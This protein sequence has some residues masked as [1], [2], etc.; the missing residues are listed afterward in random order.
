[1]KRIE[2]AT[3]YHCDYCSKVSQSKSG[4]R[5]HEISC[6]KNPNNLTPCASCKHC[7]RETYYV[8]E[9]DKYTH[10]SKEEID[11]EVAARE[12][13]Y[14]LHTYCYDR[15]E[16]HKVTE[17]TCDVDGKK[18][19]HN[20]VNRLSK[21]KREEILSRCDRQMPQECNNQESIYDDM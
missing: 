4:M 18:M 6:K 1:M 19:Y 11:A 14:N 21:E 15:L 7:I 5:V 9:D 16:Y 17:F 20:K 13:Y 12:E 8:T 3:I 2:N 10:Y